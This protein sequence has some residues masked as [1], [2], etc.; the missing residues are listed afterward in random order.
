MG[1]YTEIVIKADV[2]IGKLSE[3]EKSVLNYL[4]GDTDRPDSLPNHPFFT[5]D[6]WS[7]VGHMSSFY[8]HPKPV[9]SVSDCGEY[10]FSRSDIKNYNGEIEQFFDWFKPLTTAREGQC[11]GYTWYEED[12]IPTLIIK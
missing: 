1:M 11:I 8:H 7:Q 5:L 9:N 4:F 10:I 6:R 3:V 2:N 12:D